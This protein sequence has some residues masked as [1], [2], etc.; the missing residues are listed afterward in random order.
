MFYKIIAVSVVMGAA[1]AV[2][3]EDTLAASMV[4]A[5]DIKGGERSPAAPPALAPPPPSPEVLKLIDKNEVLEHQEELSMLQEEESE[6]KALQELVKHIDENKNEE[7][8]RKIVEKRGNV[9][10]SLSD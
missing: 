8:D 6:V 3:F 7:V 4:A 2:A 10:I 5:I 9:K 1:A